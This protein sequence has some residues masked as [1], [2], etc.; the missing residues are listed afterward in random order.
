MEIKLNVEKKH[1]WGLMCLGLLILL[2]VGAVMVWAARG[3]NDPDSFGHSQSELEG[4][5]YSQIDDSIAQYV[6]CNCRIY[7]GYG[8][9]VQDGFSTASKLE[10]EGRIKANGACENIRCKNAAGTEVSDCG[11]TMGVNSDG[12][13]LDYNGGIL[14]MNQNPKIDFLQIGLTSTETPEK[15]GYYIGFYCLKP[16]EIGYVA[17]CNP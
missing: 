8:S 15:Q 1:F 14:S 11:C 2:A 4:I 12:Y 7:F 5:A 3:D 16:S 13:G 17:D 6:R 10:K 9:G